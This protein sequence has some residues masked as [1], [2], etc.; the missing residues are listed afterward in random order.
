MNSYWTVPENDSDICHYGVKGMK[1]GVRREA[2]RDARESVRASMSYG[3]GAGNRRK[4]I[5]RSVEAKKKKDSNYAKAF[6]YYRDR[7]DVAKAGQNARKWRKSQDRKKKA[8]SMRSGAARALG[9]TSAAAMVGALG[10]GYAKNYKTINPIV[11]QAA[12][13]GK[14]WLDTQIR[15]A[16]FK[17]TM[18][19]AGIRL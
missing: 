18:K 9:Y 2:K 14:A 8:K 4:L 7:E 11:K 5:N 15:T 16:K 1:W 12:S 17:N 13:T 10:V 6:D 19:K 3:E